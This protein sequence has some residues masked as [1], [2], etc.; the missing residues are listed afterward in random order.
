[1]LPNENR[2]KLKILNSSSSLFMNLG[3]LI[4]YVSLKPPSTWPIEI[5]ILT[6]TAISGVINL[7][8]SQNAKQAA[9]IPKITATAF[10]PTF[11]LPHASHCP[12]EFGAKLSSQVAQ[13]TQLCPSLQACTF[14]P[15]R[16]APVFSASG[17]KKI[18]H[19]TTC[20]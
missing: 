3:H 6:F 14:S 19:T 7:T 1:M 10:W 12:S 9:T 15:P 8:E 16:Q 18:L 17:H 5:K 11:S 4:W 20:Q 2:S 13:E